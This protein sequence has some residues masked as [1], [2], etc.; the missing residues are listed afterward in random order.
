MPVAAMRHPWETNSWPRQNSPVSS[1]VQWVFITRGYMGPQGIPDML[2]FME[3]TKDGAGKCHSDDV[4]AAL[5]FA[6]RVGRISASDKIFTAPLWLSALK[7]YKQ[8]AQSLAPATKKAWAPP[9]ALIA[10]RLGK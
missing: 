2:D 1:I 7:S 9:V 4:Q 5:Y 6:E 10:S 8:E 3:S